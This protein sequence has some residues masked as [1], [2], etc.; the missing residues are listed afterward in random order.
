[1][2]N[3]NS[4][5]PAPNFKAPSRPACKGKRSFLGDTVPG[6]RGTFS[7]AKRDKVLDSFDPSRSILHEIIHSLVKRNAIHCVDIKERRRESGVAVVV[8]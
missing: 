3:P 7:L 1:M 4:I 8:T 5:K 2:A 6:S